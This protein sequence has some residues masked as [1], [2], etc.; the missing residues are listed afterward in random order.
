MIN[1]K[2]SYC[3]NQYHFKSSTLHTINLSYINISTWN[4]LPIVKINYPARMEVDE[5]YSLTEVKVPTFTSQLRI[6][7]LDYHF[8]IMYFRI[9]TYIFVIILEQIS[10]SLFKISLNF[11]FIFLNTCKYFHWKKKNISFIALFF[12]HYI[13]VLKRYIYIYIYIYIYWLDN[14]Y[15]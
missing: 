6:L 15:N 9:L 3:I 4:L 10:K 12:I 11:S 2:R 1:L 7:N 5:H 13:S 8:N 14:D